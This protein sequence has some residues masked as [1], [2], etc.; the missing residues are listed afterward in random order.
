MTSF[1]GVFLTDGTCSR[2]GSVPS[3]G[4]TGSL[5]SVRSRTSSASCRSSRERSRWGNA[6]FPCL[7]SR[8]RGVTG[9]SISSE[10]ATHSG[11]ARTGPG[12]SDRVPRQ[13]GRASRRCRTT[14]SGMST[15]VP[16]DA[17]A[18][19]DSPSGR[20][21]S[22][23]EANRHPMIPGRSNDHPGAT[24]EPRWSGVAFRGERGM[25]RR[26]WRPR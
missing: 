11:A 8:S 2:G 22:M 18:H 15:R 4:S 25:R 16:F 3:K 13:Q 12:A 20:G 21:F 6:A 7:S 1:P 14:S 10:H 26:E 5:S 9:S 19:D 24:R 17:S 23:A